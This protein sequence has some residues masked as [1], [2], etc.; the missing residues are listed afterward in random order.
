MLVLSRRP[1]EKILLPTVPAVIKVISSGAGLTRLGIE[2]PTHVPILR[3]EL[4]RQDRPPVDPGAAGAP[5]PNLSHFVRDRINNLVLGLTLLR[6][7]LVECDPAVRKTLA[8]MEE[9][10][11]ALRLAVAALPAEQPGPMKPPVLTAPA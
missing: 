2:A 5:G 11:Q 6:I 3:A 9:E 7:S 1:D 4:C 8:G 10:L